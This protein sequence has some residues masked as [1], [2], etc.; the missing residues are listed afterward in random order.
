[1][2]VSL[3]QGNDISLE[4]AE[5]ILKQLPTKDSR[6]SSSIDTVATEPWLRPGTSETLKRFMAEQSN[7]AKLSSEKNLPF[8]WQGLSTAHG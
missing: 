7:Q 8:N 2:L 6:R 5:D 1:M 4:H 3:P